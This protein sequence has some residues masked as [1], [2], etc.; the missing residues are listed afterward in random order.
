VLVSW[1]VMYF[2]QLP[3]DLNRSRKG[4]ISILGGGGVPWP[5]RQILGAH[6]TCKYT[7]AA[8]GICFDRMLWFLHH[9]A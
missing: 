8:A 2:K 4:I 6:A 3:Y 7:F 5:S 1:H 9:Y